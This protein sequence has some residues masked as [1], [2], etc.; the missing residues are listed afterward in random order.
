MFNLI[1]DELKLFA[2]KRGIPEY[3]NIPRKRLKVLFF[4]KCSLEIVYL[5]SLVKKKRNRRILFKYYRN[6]KYGNKR[7]SQE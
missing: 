1:A 3:R 2:E 5:D 6:K 7:L 4:H